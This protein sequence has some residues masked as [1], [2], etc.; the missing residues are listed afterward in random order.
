MKTHPSSAAAGI[1]VILVLGPVERLMLVVVELPECKFSGFS[2]SFWFVLS[3]VPPSEKKKIN[4]WTVL[5]R[6]YYKR[7]MN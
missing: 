4:K 3:L 1:V 2:F 5:M 7:K 6:K